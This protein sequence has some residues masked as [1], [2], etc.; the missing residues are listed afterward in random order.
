MTGLA[1]NTTYHFRI[2]AV[3]AGGTS[4]GGDQAFATSGAPELGR[5]VKVQSE[6]VGTKTVY[7]GGFTSVTCLVESATHT[8]QYEWEPGVLKTAFKTKI[9]TGNVTLESAVKASKV[10]CT[11]ETGS[12]EYIG[13]KSVGHVI[14]ALT[15]CEIVAPKSK[16]ASAGAEV[17]EV[18]TKPLEGDFGLET[19]GETAAKDRAGLDLYPVGKAGAVVEFSC[20]STTVAVQGSVIVPFTADKMLLTVKLKASATSGKQKPEKLL[21]GPTDVLEE[22]FD[23]EAFEQTGLTVAI[24]QTNEED[25]EVNTV[26]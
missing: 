17:G 11:G 5:C 9:T 12:G 13:L 26:V 19:L 14:L 20:G 8:G 4:Y 3:N 25:V 23:R 15:G 7:H 1:A 10:T 18:V 24:T 6:K 22:S 21:E 16:C 2:V